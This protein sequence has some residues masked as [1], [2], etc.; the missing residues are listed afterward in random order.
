MACL[1]HLFWLS[2][3][4]NF[5]VSA[6]FLA[7]L[8]NTVADDISRLHEQGRLSRIIPYVNL[9]PFPLHMSEANFSS[10]FP[11]SPD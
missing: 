5:H 1:R 11:R 10:V 7:G 4:Y 9:S 2:A 8:S 6:K 3:T